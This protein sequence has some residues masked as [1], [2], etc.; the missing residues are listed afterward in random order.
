MKRWLGEPL[1]HFLAIG[2][3]MFGVY[4]W[5]HR[6]ESGGSNDNAG[7]VRITATEISY[8][9]QTWERLQQR[10]PAREELHALVAG[11]LKDSC[12]AAKRENWAST[13]M[14]RSSAAVSR[15]RSNFW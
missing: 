14:I 12:S 13:R 11:Y 10:A 1:V 8:L 4:A 6:G 3:L 2:S 9:T 5:L 15:R 7:P